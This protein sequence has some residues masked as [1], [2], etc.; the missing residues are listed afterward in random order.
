MKCHIV[1]T[2]L[3][4]GGGGRGRYGTAYCVPWGPW[5]ILYDGTEFGAVYHNE[6]KSATLP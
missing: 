2:Y 4:G 6:N 1:T 5:V 3:G